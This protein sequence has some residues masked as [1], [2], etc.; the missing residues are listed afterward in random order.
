MVRGGF[1]QGVAEGPLLGQVVAGRNGIQTVFTF[2][3]CQ[4][5]LPYVHLICLLVK[6]NHSCLFFITWSLFASHAMP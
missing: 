2:L 1:V 3:D 5:P 4:L 6:V